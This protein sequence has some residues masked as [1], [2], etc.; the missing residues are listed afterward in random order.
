MSRTNLLRTGFQWG[1]RARRVE[2]QSPGQFVASTQW[3][4]GPVLKKKQGAFRAWILVRDKSLSRLFGPYYER[5]PALFVF[6]LCNIIAVANALLTS[7]WRDPLY[8]CAPARR[9]SIRWHFLVFSRR[10]P[11]HCREPSTFLRILYIFE[12]PLLFRGSSAL[13][14]ILCTIEDPSCWSL[15]SLPLKIW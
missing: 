14:R 8:P 12:D 2:G 1:Q 11:L 13:S 9:G 5:C 3:G 7:W 6:L 4:S 15:G 10:D